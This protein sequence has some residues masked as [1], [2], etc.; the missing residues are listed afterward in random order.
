MHIM[1]KLKEKLQSGKLTRAE[2]NAA[3]PSDDSTLEW[4]AWNDLRIAMNDR[5]AQLAETHETRL[6]SLE[7]MLVK[8]I[9]ETHDAF[10]HVKLEQKKISSNV[11]EAMVRIEKL[12]TNHLPHIIDDIKLIKSKLEL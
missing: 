12:M 11:D 3:Q 4:K 2:L 6:S 10:A 9:T 1:D 5:T 8:H 7:K